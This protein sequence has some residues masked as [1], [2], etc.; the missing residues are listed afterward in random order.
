MLDIVL[1][2]FAKKYNSTKQPE[3]DGITYSGEFKN[4]SSM[5]SP[6][7]MLYRGPAGTAA[8]INKN[9]AYIAEFDR[10]YF[11]RDWVFEGGLWVA[12]MECDLLATWKFRIGYSD[13]YVLRSSVISLN[14]PYLQ[15]N[16]WLNSVRNTSYNVYDYEFWPA[17]TISDGMFVIGVV[18]DNNVSDMGM[19]SYY[20]LTSSQFRSLGTALFADLNLGDLGTTTEDLAKAL[21][22]PAEYIT[23]CQWFPFKWPVVPGSFKPIKVGTWDTQ[24]LGLPINETPFYT[25]TKDISLP[26]HPQSGY[27]AYM[28]C[29]PYSNYSL[30]L[31]PWGTI[32]IEPSL[33]IDCD[34]ITAVVTVDVVSGAGRLTLVGNNGGTAVTNARMYCGVSKVGVDIAITSIQ[35]NP[36]AATGVAVAK[37]VAS[38][39]GGF[40]SA[41]SAIGDAVA[42]VGTVKSIKG[43]DGAMLT[44]INTATL[45]SQFFFQTERD[46]DHRGL[47]CG[48]NASPADAGNGYYLVMDGEIEAPASG[49]ELQSIKGMLENGFFYE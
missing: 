24:A 5:L 32:V 20:A 29:S 49:E 10:Y 4:S 18:S 42:T 6:V 11:V 44:L 31:E 9:Y 3:N 25:V 41:A 7:V 35:W 1:Y 19:T 38:L 47:P 22:N 37:D 39:F 14:D 36:I 12:Y 48:K 34:S 17:G 13:F 43:A 2:E 30:E 45:H 40:G 21:V 27:G 28:N 8:P 23:S 33:F 26:K 15:D 46:I 16:A